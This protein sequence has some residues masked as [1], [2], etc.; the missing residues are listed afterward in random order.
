MER[1]AVFCG[2]SEGASDKY[3][4][5]AVQLGKALAKKGI[6]LVYGGSSVGL[7]GAV[8]NA[9]LE[10]GGQAIG[11]IPEML[12]DRELA[13]PDLTELYIVQSMQERKAKM[14]EL[15]DGF[16]AL[17]GGPGTLEEFM[18]IFTSA[19]LGIHDKPFG[20]L[21]TNHYYDPLISLFNHMADQ[22]FLGE[23]YRS[24][25][26]VDASPESLIIKLSAANC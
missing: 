15:A 24:L 8:A 9:S 12:K 3:K 14:T 11:V 1:L 25:A 6:T 21:N 7:M 23:T 5:G 26:L 18:E 2:S 22:Q 19:Q 17:P 20:L 10:N 13:H 4:Q 16:I